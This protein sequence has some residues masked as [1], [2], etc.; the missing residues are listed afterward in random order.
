MPRWTLHH[1]EETFVTGCCELGISPHVV[2]AAVNHV[3]GFRGGVAVV[4]IGSEYEVPIRQCMAIWERHV[5]DIAEGRVQG[6]RVVP[7]RA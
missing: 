4:T 2:E 5:L 6:D 7:L 3:S 1:F